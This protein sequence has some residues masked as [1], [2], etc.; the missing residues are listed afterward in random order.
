M[1]RALNL[2]EVPRE[3]LNALGGHRKIGKPMVTRLCA[4]V[5]AAKKDA[6]LDSLKASLS[7]VGIDEAASAPTAIA[8]KTLRSLEGQPLQ[9]RDGSSVLSGADGQ[10]LGKLKL[11]GKT[12]QVTLEKGM[13]AAQEK[14]VLEG[15]TALLRKALTGSTH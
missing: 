11:G 1:S 14:I 9:D 2:A 4:L 7:E 8:L 15:L 10:R 6:K 12:V 3:F 5:V 13:S